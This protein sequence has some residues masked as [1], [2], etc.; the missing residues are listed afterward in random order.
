MEEAPNLQNRVSELLEKWWC[1]DG[2]E[3]E[4]LVPNC[5]LYIMART[6]NE[7]AK[8]CG[9]NEDSRIGHNITNHHRKL[10]DGAG[11]G[12]G[13]NVNVFSLVVVNMEPID[14]DNTN[15]RS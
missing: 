1:V 13:Y 8:V 2:P 3:K 5:L 11:P 6:L 12:I 14:L 15:P 10:S 7:R 4:D 9:C